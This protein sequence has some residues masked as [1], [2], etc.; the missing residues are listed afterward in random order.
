MA[1]YTTPPRAAG[2]T[3]SARFDQITSD[4]SHDGN[5][6]L[7]EYKL[8]YEEYISVKHRCRVLDKEKNSLTTLLSEMDRSFDLATRIDPM[9]GLANRRA[10]MEKMGQELSRAH[11][12]ERTAS[13]IYINIDDFFK[14]NDVHGYNDGDD[15]LVEVARVLMGCARSEDI[16]ARWGG[17]EFLFLLAETA[18]EGAVILSGKV[19]EAITMTEFKANRP[20]IRI[21]ASMGVCELK[22]GNTAQ[23]FVLCADQA[24]RRAKM[25]GK[26][27]FVVGD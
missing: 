19:L 18:I 22:K 26:N 23:E 11:R 3:V 16:C 13:L 7:A 9:T 25:L 4:S 15:V 17:D 6:L 27:R 20:G 12:Y 21:T 10:I 5:P 1:L 14:V 2:G 8:L 24:L